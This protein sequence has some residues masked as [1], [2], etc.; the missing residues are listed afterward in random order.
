MGQ[1]K[2]GDQVAKDGLLGDVVMVPFESGWNGRPVYMAKLLKPG[3]AEEVIPSLIGARV[4][5]VRRSMLITGE[6]QVPQGRKSVARFQQTWLCAAERISPLEWAARPRRS[7][8]I[9]GFD[10]ADDDREDL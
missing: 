6:E 1:R 4:I 7:N 3:T 8:G 10:P 2:G 9:P 5:G